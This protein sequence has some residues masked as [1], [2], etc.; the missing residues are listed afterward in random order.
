[1]HMVF[2]CLCYTF[3]KQK[4]CFVFPLFFPEQKQQQIYIIMVKKNGLTLTKNII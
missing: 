4:A 3:E 1:M 2:V